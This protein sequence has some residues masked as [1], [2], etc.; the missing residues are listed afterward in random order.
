MDYSFVSPGEPIVIVGPTDATVGGEACGPATVT[1]PLKSDA[2]VRWCCEAGCDSDAESMHV[3]HP[4]LGVIDFPIF[5]ESMHGFG[6]PNGSPIVGAGD[7][8][9][10]AIS[11]LWLNLPAIFAWSDG[12]ADHPVDLAVDGWR[13]T[14]DARPDFATAERE[15]KAFR[16][17]FVATH[18]SKLTRDDGAAFTAETGLDVLVGFQT[19]FSFGLGRFVAPVLPRGIDSAGSIRWEGWQ[20]WRCDPRWGVE[21]WLAPIRKDDV[22]E[23]LTRFVGSWLD[24]DHRPTIR[25]GALGSVCAHN[26]KPTAEAGVLLAQ[27]ELEALAWRKLVVS[28]VYSAAEYKA[29]N[30]TDRITEMLATCSIDTTIPD[31]LEAL[32]D[33][34]TEPGMTAPQ[35]GPGVAAWVRNR[36]THPKDPTIP[37]EIENLVWHTKLLLLEYLDLA[38]L[39]EI[40]YTGGLSRLYPPGR[41]SGTTEPVPWAA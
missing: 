27:A 3:T 29:V 26:P 22:S 11:A 38:L 4:H 7:A 14:M 15:A 13:L 32:L 21:S 35:S 39:H 5:V 18:E 23:L 10:T 41:W 25:Y 40:G 37:Y 9:V 1:L 30:A 6:S 36:L 2:R 31:D 16:T 24:D 8:E 17:P 20:D 12:G 33:L 28:G 19:A 34:A